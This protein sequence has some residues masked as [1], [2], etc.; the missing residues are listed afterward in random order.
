ME[1]V[2]IVSNR[3]PIKLDI[4]DDKVTVEESSGGLATG[5]KSFHK[6]NESLWIGW[7]GTNPNERMR[8]EIERILGGIQCKPVYLEESL[9]ENYYDGFSNSTIW[10]LFH[11]FPEYS[12][13]NHEYW[14]AYIEVNKRFADE[15]LKHV[16]K[17]ENVWI[18]DYQLMLVPEMLKKHR[19]DLNIGFFLHIPFPSYEIFRIIP[20]RDEL[21]NGLMGADLIGFHTYDYARH[22]LS[23]VKRLIGNEVNFNTIITDRGQIEVD[24]FPMGIDYD[25]FHDTSVLVQNKSL[26]EK[27][28]EHSD[29]EKYFERK[30]DRKLILSIDRLDYSKGIPNRL[31][32]F[33]DFLS[34]HPEYIEKVSL[35]MLTV[36]SR[37]DVEKYQELRSTIDELVGRINGEFGTINWNPV[38][39]FYRSLPFENL[40]ELY[41]S[42]DIALV[43]PLRDGMNLVAKE[44]IASQNQNSGVLIIS[45]LAGAAKEL[46]EAIL[47]NPTDIN[48]L[49]SAIYKALLADEKEKANALNLMKS[50]IKRYDVFK[51]AEDFMSKLYKV[52]KEAKKNKTRKVGDQLMRMLSAKYKAAKK[53]ILFLDYDGT[54]QCFYDDPKDAKP[55]SDLLRILLSLHNNKNREIVIISGRDKDTLE[56][57]FGEMGYSI[58][59]EHGAFLKKKNEDWEQLKHKRNDWSDIVKPLL[60]SYVDRTPGSFIEEKSFSLVWHFR[61]SDVDLG[62]I[63]AREL[64]EELS[65]LLINQDLE[66]LE[67]NKVIEVKISGINKGTAATDYLLNQKHDFILAVG[68]D[69]T[70]EYLF[71]HWLI[72]HI[73]LK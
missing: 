13:F 57:W 23:S 66:V 4:K 32:G 22:F 3:L 36:P 29:I 62:E 1:K 17:D 20:W 41:S 42:A 30:N 27:S 31:R 6:E 16:N 68:D 37:E 56:A 40:I 33:H 49:S 48:D 67:G 64:K 14:E 2:I 59:A 18:H 63:R 50:R 47:V 52:K 38:I 60:E 46:S 5:L 9:I 72:K 44:Y 11:Y 21:I 10:P 25:K 70:D 7:P 54:L 15:I 65:T 45:E 8:N 71:K 53:S 69:W 55:D 12:D 61:K 51:W 24:V 28:K 19:K 35:L 73:P 43:T 39:Y 34:K 26:K 58:I